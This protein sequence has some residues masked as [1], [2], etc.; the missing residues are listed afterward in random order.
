[1]VVLTLL[2]TG[3]RSRICQAKLRA[4]LVAG[5]RVFLHMEKQ[6]LQ[7]VAG[8][9]KAAHQMRVFSQLQNRLQRRAGSRVFAGF[10]QG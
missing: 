7:A 6:R 5:S 9:K 8:I 3:P 1:M 2:F 10:P 4:L